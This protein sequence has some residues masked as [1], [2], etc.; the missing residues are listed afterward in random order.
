[1][2]ATY[3]CA[4]VQCSMC[5]CHLALKHVFPPLQVS[6]QLNQVLVLR[7]RLTQLLRDSLQGLPNRSPVPA[8]RFALSTMQWHDM[9]QSVRPNSHS[10]CDQPI[11]LLVEAKEPLWAPLTFQ[12]CYAQPQTR[13]VTAWSAVCKR[14]VCFNIYYR[15][16]DWSCVVMR[17]WMYKRT[18]RLYWYHIVLR[19]WQSQCR[20]LSVCM[21]CRAAW[22]SA[23]K[24]CCWRARSCSKA[25]SAACCSCCWLCAPDS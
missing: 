21:T 24:T 12:A 3:F 8:H 22:C 16:F 19:S 9:L 20:Y 2:S 7:F 15:G 25:C 18:F 1:M 11:K 13:S 4:A 17:T 23:V 6:L 14:F 10:M 5:W